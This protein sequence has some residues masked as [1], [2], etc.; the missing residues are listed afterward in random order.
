MERISIAPRVDWAAKLQALGFDWHTPNGQTYWDETAYWRLSQAE[1]D[2]LQASAKEAYAMMLD[3]IEFVIQSR[4]LPLFG[5]SNVVA[6][7][8]EKSWEESDNEPT[9]YGRF[10]L[11]YDGSQAKILEYNGDNPGTLFETSMVQKA[12]RQD[13]LPG[14]AQFNYLHEQLVAMFRNVSLL[15]RTTLH[16]DNDFNPL[17]HLTCLTP[18]AEGE[19]TCGYLQKAAQ[20]GGVATSFIGLPDIGWKDVSYNDEDQPG[21][22]CDLSNNRISTLVKLAPLGWMF[23]DDFGARLLEEVMDNRLRLIEPAWKLLASNKR[24]L[25]AMWD[26]YTYH[27]VLLNTSTTLTP[28]I[29]AKGYAKK[30]VNGI[31]G[32][33]ILLVGADGATVDETQGSFI[34]DQFIYQ[35]RAA[36]AQSGGNFAV[37][38]TWLVGGE[39]VALG[40]REATTAI[41]D[42]TA[43]FVPHVVG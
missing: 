35:E 16:T 42:N 31:E 20:E 9:L 43:R 19:G 34:E 29:R 1:V 15:N 10:D 27:P 41:T 33:N 32:Q 39:A 23:Q 17:V 11:A 7:L 37:M 12:W 26:R 28:D 40:I 4:Q 38:G 6:E 30:P 13:V 25:A 18:S 22:F 21:F 24:I 3:T 2:H 14:S 5:Y 36:M 8:I